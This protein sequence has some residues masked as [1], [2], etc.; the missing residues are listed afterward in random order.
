[1]SDRGPSGNTIGFSFI[2]PPLSALGTIL[3]GQ[4]GALL[5]VQ[6]DAT[7]WAATTA[8]VIDGS[9]ATVASYGPITLIPEPGS[10]ALGSIGLLAFGGVILRGRRRRAAR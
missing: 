5:V 4:S 7:L 8:Q 1:M 6:T 10:L 3:P 2:G 9:V